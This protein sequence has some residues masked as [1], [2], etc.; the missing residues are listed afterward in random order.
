[1][2]I[3]VSSEADVYTTSDNEDRVI[4]SFSNG[5]NSFTYCVLQWTD[6]SVD[7]NLLRTTEKE[8]ALFDAEN[9]DDIY[10]AVYDLRGTVRLQAILGIFTT[11]LVCVVLGSGAMFFSK[12]TTDLVI[13][14]WG[15]LRHKG[16][17]IGNRQPV[18]E[19][20]SKSWHTITVE[21]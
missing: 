17:K 7:V 2:N 13:W 6:N 8:V 4:E 11:I 14:G 1:M 3:S 12:L 10:M 21:E 18:E 19:S 9:Q 15:L 16:V 20:G 5:T